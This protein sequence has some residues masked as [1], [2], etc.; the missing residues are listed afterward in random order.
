ML[1]GEDTPRC[2]GHQIAV[3]RGDEHRRAVGIHFVQ[4]R[5]DFLSQD[6]IEVPRRF[7]GQDESWL[8]DQSP[9]QRHTLLLAPRQLLWQRILS[10]RDAHARQGFSH[11][12]SNPTLGNG[13]DALCEGHVFKGGFCGKKLEILKDDAKRTAKFWNP[14]MGQACHIAAVDD[15]VSLIRRLRSIEQPQQC[16]LPGTA[17]ACEDDELPGFYPKRD[18]FESRPIGCKA[19][20]DMEHLDHEATGGATARRI[21]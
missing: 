21:P 19:L 9:R 13:Q 11:P 15:N 14:S 20:E 17:G 2:R 12:A 18:V 16:R 4:K 3:M 10:V 1:E 8:I 6:I 5:H 7:I